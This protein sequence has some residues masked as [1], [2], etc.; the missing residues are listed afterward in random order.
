[1]DSNRIIQGL[2]IGSSLSAMERLCISSFLKH[3]HE[4]HLYTYEDVARIP[5]ST[6]VCDANSILPASSVFRYSNGSYAGFANYFRYKLLLEKG[7]WW[8]DLDTVC[9]KPFDFTAE[10]VFA[11]HLQKDGASIVCSG[12]IKSPAGSAFCDYA[13]RVCQRKDP[14]RLVWGE[15]GPVLTSEAVNHLGLQQYVV[16]AETFCPVHGHVWESIFDGT[17]R[18]EFGSA[19]Y[20][21]HLWNELWRREGLDKDRRYESGCLYELLKA[22]YQTP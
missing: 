13:W 10:Y 1:M 5:A 14:Q 12:I 6:V 21:V 19:T 16:P 8:V 3:G 22:T 18:H 15:T 9:L 7:G 4:F 11:S 2:W 17:F 20:A